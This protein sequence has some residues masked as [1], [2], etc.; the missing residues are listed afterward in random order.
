M[1]T[2]IRRVAV[3]KFTAVI[4]S[5]AVFGLLAAKILPLQWLFS[6]FL[7]ACVFGLFFVGGTGYRILIAVFFNDP[8][9]NTA[10]SWAGAIAFST[11][12]VVVAILFIVPSEN[13]KLLL[14]A[15]YGMAINA[16]YI[17][18]K[19]A[20]LDA[21]CCRVHMDG[22]SPRLL[23]VIPDLRIIEFLASIAIFA[24]SF[25]LALIEMQLFLA[26]IVSLAGHLIVRVLSRFA[27]N[28]LPKTIGEF[29]NSGMELIPLV[30]A[31]AVT[32]QTS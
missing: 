13:H 17:L 19:L 26:A 9:R 23:E 3:L 5:A 29:W 18:V 12:A 27:R 31:I 32:L 30:V 22:M 14:L 25:Y 10:T 4:A 16:G 2:T 20:C 24:L 7:L 1:K 28:R 11:L 15:S 6:A 21:G 8:S